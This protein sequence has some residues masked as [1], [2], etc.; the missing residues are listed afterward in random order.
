MRS[1]RHM[2]DAS[3][4]TSESGQAS[5]PRRLLTLST[6]WSLC[7]AIL[8][9][10]LVR[11]SSRRGCHRFP[12]CSSCR[13]CC[14][15]SQSLIVNR[16]NALALRARVCFVSGAGSARRFAPRQRKVAPWLSTWS[17]KRRRRARARCSSPDPTTSTGRSWP[18]SLRPTATR[19]RTSRRSPGSTSSRRT[20]ST[21]RVFS[22]P[23]HRRAFSWCV[24]QPTRTYTHAC[25]RTHTHTHTHTHARTHT[26]THARARARAHAPP[27]TPPPHAQFFTP[28]SQSFAAC[29]RACAYSRLTAVAT[30]IDSHTRLFVASVH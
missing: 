24:A 25:T 1:A 29:T 30:S 26:H 13:C 10:T 2:L 28:P 16:R 6:W 11:P 22:S 19:T 8:L 27:P 12:C 21:F 5:C 4:T 18:T 3:E 23:F 14:R 7:T 15:C 9:S 20:F 17:T